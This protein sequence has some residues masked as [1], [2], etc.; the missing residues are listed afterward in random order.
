MITADATHALARVFLGTL[1]AA[2]AWPVQAADAAPGAPLVLEAEMPIPDVP[3]GPY[4]DGI[5][6][7][8]QGGRLFATP[9]AAGA[10]VVLDLASGKVLGRIGGF[11]QLHGVYFDQATQRLFVA[12]GKSEELKVYAGGDLKPVAGIPLERGGDAVE[13][14]AGK[15]LLYV[16]NGGEDAGMEHALLTVIDPAR[17]SKVAQVEISGSGL[18]SVAIDEQG[19]RLYVSIYNASAIAVVDMDANR[20]VATWKLPAGD[21]APHGLALDAANHRLYVSCRDNLTTR[22]RPVGTLFALDTASGRTVATEAIGGWA[23][24]VALDARR[25]RLYVTSGA[26]WINTFRIEGNDHLTR[27]PDVET[28]LISKHGLYSSELDRLFVDT[29]SL[30]LTEA[31]VLVFRPVP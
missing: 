24:E 22:E 11:R 16:V 31:R 3:T 10:V 21:H 6:V 7:D 2:G 27:L 14:D 9:Q 5:A 8:V 19:R 15:R 13:Y 25:R 18:E 20:Q 26:G 1:L 12:D 28:A 4:A 30:A 17:L 23:D 29:P